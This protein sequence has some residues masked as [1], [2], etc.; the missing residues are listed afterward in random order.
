MNEIMKDEFKRFAIAFSIMLI[1]DLGL[2]YF[3]D[4]QNFGK[5]FN[6]HVG[7]FFAVALL[8]GPYG[9]WGSLSGIVLSDLIRGY[10]IEEVILSFIV[11]FIISFLAY[12]LWYD[13]FDGKSFVEIPGFSN[14]TSLLKFLA[15]LFFTGVVFALFIEIIFPLCYPNNNFVFSV[16]VS[17]FIDYFNYSFVITLCG[18]FICQKFNFF[19]V[20]EVSKKKVNTK[21][22]RVLFSIISVLVVIFIIINYLFVVNNYILF[23]E[24]ISLVVLF[25]LYLRKPFNFELKSIPYNSISKK[26]IRMFLGITVCIAIVGVILSFETLLTYIFSEVFDVEQ[27]SDLILCSVDVIIFLFFI[28]TLIILKYI[29]NN[30]IN[31]IISFSKIGGLVKKNEVIY[32][33]DLIGVYNKYLNRDDEIG[34]LSRASVDL[35]NYNNDYIENITKIEGEKQRIGTELS[36]ARN[37]QASNLPPEPLNNEFFTVSGF[38]KSAKEVCGD[39]YD[40]FMLDEDTLVMVIGDASG[41]GVP[42]ALLSTIAQKLIKQ[43]V[44]FNSTP[45][46]ILFSLNNS[47]CENNSE[48][49]FVTL[50]LGFYNKRTR[51][52][53]FSNAGH[54]PPIVGNSNGFKYMGLDSGLILGVSEDFDYKNEE[55][56]VDTDLILYTDGLTDAENDKKAL[57]G[58]EGLL[59]FFNNVNSLDENIIDEVISDINS[60]VGNAEQADDMTILR[61]HDK[62]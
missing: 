4:S 19:K 43:L 39:F 26:I 42:A 58:E 10:N 15:L 44:N 34:A 53:V 16:G 33:D 27:I 30:V 18:I 21:F 61:L 47:L 38:S 51:K 56:I 25:C 23:I 31:P 32:I 8:L 7:V 60:F 12:K 24:F 41:K 5:G 45:A 22:Y 17:Y 6:L 49:M 29:E 20:P 55:F 11:C 50:W 35:I 3:G 59:N 40:Y 48:M 2:F 54:N 1:A 57:Y 62:I 36:I 46:D 14:T 37:I 13:D 9:I 52:V 28:P